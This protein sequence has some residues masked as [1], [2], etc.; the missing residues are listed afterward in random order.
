MRLENATK[1]KGRDYVDNLARN[2][3]SFAAHSVREIIIDDKIDGELVNI[4]I[5]KA[6]EKKVVEKF[7]MALHQR[8]VTSEKNGRFV[9]EKLA[10]FSHWK[11]HELRIDLNPHKTIKKNQDACPS[12]NY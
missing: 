8:Y 9:S 11:T 6:D 2:D 10:T 4:Q 12:C 3:I 1:V 5:V 7:N